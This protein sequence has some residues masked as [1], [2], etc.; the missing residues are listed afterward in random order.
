MNWAERARDYNALPAQKDTGLIEAMIRLGEIDKS[1]LVLDVGTGTGIMADA[2]APL[3]DR[4]IAIDTSREMAAQ[5]KWGGNKFFISHNAENALFA[6]NAF[7]R[8]FARKVFHCLANPTKAF[9]ECYRIL[10]KGGRLVL[11]VPVPQSVT[12]QKEFDAIFKE[13]DSRL[14]LT[15]PKYAEMMDAV[16]FKEMRYEPYFLRG[17][18]VSDWMF[19]SGLPT[20]KQ[21]KIFA[22]HVWASD[23][24]KE[25]YNM[26]IIRGDCLVD[27]KFAVLVGIK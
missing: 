23:E 24:F 5:Y 22:M 1:H 15:A 4:V 2:L 21:D 11:S 10:K 7:D 14:T 17:M 12:V 3:V 9:R 19:H 18:S 27:V 16:G 25:R 26:R 13:K 6:D 20:D 8:I